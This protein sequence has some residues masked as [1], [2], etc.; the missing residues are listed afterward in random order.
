MKFNPYMKILIDS[1]QVPRGRTGVGVY[2]EH[3]IHE[4]AIISHPEDMIFVLVQKD[5]ESMRKIIAGHASLHPL[6]IDS[7]LFRNRLALALYEQFVLPG[8]LL[9]HRIDL[10]HSLHYRFPLLRPCSRIVTLHD[11]THLLWPEMHTMGRRLTMSFFAKMALR[12]AEG[13]L[14]VSESTRRDAEHI[15]GVGQNLRSVTPLGVDNNCY[16]RISPAQTKDALLRLNIHRPYILFL[17]TLEPRKNL[18]RLIQAFELVGQHHSEH[19]LVIGGGLG[20]H[21]EPTLQA[22]QTSPM[23]ARIHYLGYI[24]EQ[25]KIPLIAGCDLLAYPSL[26]EGFGL[27]VLEGM[28]AGVAVVTSNTSSLPEVAGEAAIMVDPAS[29]EQIATAISSVLSNRQYSEELRQAGKV[30]ASQFSWEKTAELTYAAYERLKA[31]S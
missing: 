22:L 25:D 21:Y 2:A 31:G 4:L 1:T 29:V 14:F 17:G 24:S 18:M 20:W 8:I 19:V 6:I 26:Y 27:P 3:L 13:V 7:S 5:D 23:K 30:Q 16:S 9:Y 15:F 12:H 28:A 11:M 10:L